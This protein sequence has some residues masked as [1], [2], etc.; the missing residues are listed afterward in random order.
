MYKTI[1]ISC[2]KCFVHI[3]GLLIYNGLSILSPFVFYWGIE[4]YL[5]LKERKGQLLINWRSFYDVCQ[6]SN[7]KFKHVDNA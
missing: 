4:T 1:L 7:D 3:G 5:V 6:Y 2:K